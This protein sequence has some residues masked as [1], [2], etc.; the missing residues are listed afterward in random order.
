[1]SDQNQWDAMEDAFILSNKNNDW[2]DKLNSPEEI[3]KQ[4]VLHCEY[5]RSFRTKWIILDPE[6]KLTQEEE[7]WQGQRVYSEEQLKEMLGE[8][9]RPPRVRDSNVEP[10]GEAEDSQ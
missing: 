4:K 7:A 5:L 1:M 10:A 6:Y 2:W 8:N 9:Y 3:E